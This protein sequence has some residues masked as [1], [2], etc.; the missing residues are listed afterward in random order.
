MAMVAALRAD[1]VVAKNGD[2]VTGD[3]VKKDDKSLTIK[4]AL[5][6]VVTLPWDQVASV[7]AEKPLNVVLPG[8]QTVQ[9]TLA[10]AGGQVE[11]GQGDG[12]RTVAPSEIVALR[13]AAEQKNHERML[14]PGFADLWVFTGSIGLAGTSGNAKTSTFT[15]PFTAS[16]VTRKDKTTAYFNFVKA[17]ALINGVSADT[18]Q[19]VRGGWSYSRNL[20]SRLFWNAFNDYEFD[21]FQNLDLRVVIG[22]GLGYNAWK[23]ERG[24]LDLT[25][26]LAWNHE[27]FDPPVRPR[28]PFTRNSAEAYWGDDFTYKLSSRLNFAQSYRMFNNLYNRGAYRQNFDTGLSAKLTGWLTW[29]ASLS[30]RFLSN[31]VRGRKKNDLLYT[32]GLGFTFAR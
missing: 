12:K 29:N 10:T 8:G 18:A 24:R 23:G 4:T 2:R 6:G 17:S 27:R 28:L 31:P 1:V 9:A 22:S 25:G 32:T 5:F 3:I 14:S 11:V 30:D 26:G 7:T 13:D 15:T 20:K 16:R 19:A 21:K